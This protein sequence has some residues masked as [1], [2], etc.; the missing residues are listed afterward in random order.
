VSL[1]GV[2]RCGER[3]PGSRG[4][5]GGRG[6][7]ICGVSGLMGLVDLVGLLGRWMDGWGDRG[8]LAWENEARCEGRLIGV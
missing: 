1:A 8:G 5:S 6:W 2:C 3:G 7:G 4:R